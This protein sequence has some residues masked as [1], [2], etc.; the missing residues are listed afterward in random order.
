MKK[1]S[2]ASNYLCIAP[3]F[4]SCVS[5]GKQPSNDA[6]RNRLSFSFPDSLAG[7][8]KDQRQQQQP[9]E[10]NSESIIDPAAS[11]ITR[12]DG[13]HCTVIVGTI[14]GHRT[15]RVTFCV[16]RDAAVP[17]PFLF[18][19]SV[20]MQS[21]ATEMASGLLR[22]ALECH[23][24]SGTP[25]DGGGG[26]G[27]NAAA[28]GS[29]SRNVWKASCNGRDVGYAVRR[30]PT[31]WDRRVLESM[32]TM[33]T[34]VGM[35]PPAVALEGPNDENL[36]DDGGAG[37]VLYMRATY[38]RIVGSRDAVSYHLIS[39]GTAGG[40]PPQELSVFLLRTRGD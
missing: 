32:R 38:E 25:H 24:P 36:Q 37:E 10:Q 29:T 20:P 19:L 31:K 21:L 2:R 33:T 8:S 22:I 23:R 12:K 28:G 27:S 14:F 30:R 4:S 17:P 18:E 40:S 6:G 11:I 34:G 1:K 35:L 5:S 9:E 15:G 13:R 16:Q 3:I 26:G 7:G 39:P